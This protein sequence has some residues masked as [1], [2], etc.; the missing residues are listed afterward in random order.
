MS[1]AVPSDFG[2][3][4]HGRHVL[5][6]GHTG[7]KGGWISH[8]LMQLGARVTGIALAPDPGPNL[9]DVTG[10]TGNMDSRL[11]DIRDREALLMQA[12]D[13]D[14]DLMIHMAA[15]PFVRRSYAEPAATFATNVS[16]TAHVLDLARAMPSLKAAIVVT[17]DKC[18]ENNE[19]SWGYRE[20]D[21]MGG[22]DPYSASKGAT[23]LVAQA[24]QR[25]FFNTADGP[26]LATVRAGN[27]F[28]G[29]DWG[30]DRLIPDIVRATVAGQPVQIRNPASIRPW[31]HV[32][33]PLSGYLAL[34]ARLLTDGAPFA[35]P[36]NFGPDISGTVNVR[37][38]AAQM[39]E[40]WGTNGPQFEFGQADPKMHEAGVL[41]LDSTKAQTQLGW[42]PQLDLAHAVQMTV[43]WYRAHQANENMKEFTMSQIAHYGALMSGASQDTTSLAAQ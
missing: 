32:L 20:N 36:W 16:G 5:V 17:S 43:D 37:E 30:E 22:S 13:I 21:P 15:Q 29:G 26:Q 19:W 4:F 25:S 6:T 24:Y 39:Q 1:G 40:S 9:C 31:Q 23:E 8:W 41:R 35:G 42:R 33:E 34:A 11:I 14:A 38:L 18:Y 27:V 3:T 2:G 10:L 12:R 28:G 7:F